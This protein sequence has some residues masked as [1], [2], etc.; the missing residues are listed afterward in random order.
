[1]RHHFL[2][3]EVNRSFASPLIS[4]N[5]KK[6]EIEDR[7][8]HLFSKSVKKSFCSISICIIILLMNISMIAVAQNVLSPSVDVKEKQN[9]GIAENITELNCRQ[10]L[11]RHVYI[12]T[13]DSGFFNEYLIRNSN[14]CINNKPISIT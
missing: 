2:S 8:N 1:M 9:I 7:F 11:L 5:L 14:L 3:P 10:F 4:N 6:L 13:D 12:F